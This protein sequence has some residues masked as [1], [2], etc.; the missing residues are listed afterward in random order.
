MS[1]INFIFARFSHIFRCLFFCKSS[2]VSLKQ[3]DLREVDGVWTPLVV[4]PIV[5]VSEDG[6]AITNVEKSSLEN[7]N[8]SGVAILSGLPNN[9]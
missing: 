7:R 9:P 6:P 2:R 3:I 5:L 4:R 8:N 1:P